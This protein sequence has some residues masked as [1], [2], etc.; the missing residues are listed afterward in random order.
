VLLADDQSG[1]PSAT[2]LLRREGV[3]GRTHGQI[4]SGSVFAA[5]CSS[6][7]CRRCPSWDG[8]SGPARKLRRGFPVG[9]LHQLL[10]TLQFGE[11]AAEQRRLAACFE[12]M[13]TLLAGQ[14]AVDKGM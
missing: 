13:A 11:A 7:R 4:G 8:M 1:R 10:E 2:A 6:A 5:V 14:L 12:H 9:G 3:Y